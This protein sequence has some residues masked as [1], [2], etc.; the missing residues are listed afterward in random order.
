MASDNVRVSRIGY[1]LALILAKSV[2]FLS[3]TSVEFVLALCCVV[4]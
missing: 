2:V 1:S 4:Y 3:I